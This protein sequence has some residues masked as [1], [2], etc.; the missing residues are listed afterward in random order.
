MIY[1]AVSTE[2]VYTLTLQSQVALVGKSVLLLHLGRLSKLP[3]FSGS[4]GAAH[5]QQVWW[6]LGVEVPAGGLH[7]GTFLVAQCMEHSTKQQPFYM[8]LLGKRR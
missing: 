4:P 6:G 8:F 2:C 1:F 5:A 7:P 3:V